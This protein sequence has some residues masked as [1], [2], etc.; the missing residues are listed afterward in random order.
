MTS[1]GLGSLGHAVYTGVFGAALG[2]ATWITNRAL[3][4]V[5]S[6][7]GLLL[8]ILLHS[9]H[10][11]LAEI[12]LVIRF[13]WGKTAAALSGDFL[14]VAEVEKI[15]SAYTSAY[16]ALYFV[17]LA[18][19]LAFFGLIAIWLWYQRR[20]I[21]AQLCEEVDRNL[22]TQS[23]WELMPRY[24]QRSKLYWQM[25][26][27]GRLEVW[28]LIRRIHNEL[29]DLAFLKWRTRFGVKQAE[30][31]RRRARIAALKQLEPLATEID[32]TR[33]IPTS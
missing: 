6:I 25:L 22:I 26:R 7:A 11:G 19:V 8:T 20:V 32:K 12:W 4:V 17:D 9:V 3:K 28:R 2:L 13:G 15:E 31:D 18:L 27:E 33:V 30:V 16:L 21:N 5:V 1:L 24:W 14:P 23:E 10:N 29:A